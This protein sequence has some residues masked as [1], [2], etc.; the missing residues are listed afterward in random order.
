[1]FAYNAG[2]NGGRD[3]ADFLPVYEQFVAARWK[4]LQIIGEAQA[5]ADVAKLPSA[6]IVPP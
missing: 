4:G 2:E 3:V 1:M 6:V 5:G